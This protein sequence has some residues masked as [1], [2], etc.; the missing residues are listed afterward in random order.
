MYG[1]PKAIAK[2]TPLVPKS[3]STSA[4]ATPEGSST[5]ADPPATAPEETMKSIAELDPADLLSTPTATDGETATESELDSELDE[6]EATPIPAPVTPKIAKMKLSKH[7][8]SLSV[9]SSVSDESGRKHYTKKQKPMSQ[10]DL[11][12]KYFRRDTVVVRNL[13]VLR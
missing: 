6:A 3:R 2:R 9:A 8:S 12:N 7:K 13:D 4:K 1:Q 11:L 5:P 10:H